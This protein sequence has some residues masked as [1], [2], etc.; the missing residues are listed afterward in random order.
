MEVKDTIT[1]RGEEVEVTNCMMKQAD[2]RFFPENPRIYSIVYVS[3]E[4]PRQDKIEKKLGQLDHVKQLV[5]SIE[6]NKGLIDPLIVRKGDNT[7]LEGN[8]RLAAYRLLAKKD[9]IMWGKVKCSMLPEDI[10]EDLIFALLGEYHIIGRKDWAPFEQAGYLYRRFK[11]HGVTPARM[12]K[13]LALSVMKINHLIK[14]YEFM[15]EN[16]EEDVQRWSYYDE[17]L[18][19]KKIAKARDDHLEMDQVIV[20]K[21][22]TGEIPKAVD[23][24]SK[25]VKIASVGG[26]TLRKFLET[27]N[28]LEICHER[29]IARGVDNYLLKRLNKFRTYILDP[30]TKKDLAYMPENQLKKCEFE[31]KKILK[32]V[33]KLLERM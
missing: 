20:E 22:K 17:Y 26:K 3:D 16:D 25:V 2:L 7:V 14:V 24:R 5:Q 32:G 15:V 30:D 18:K 10:S 11:K 28:S 13:E 6:A 19:S 29:A 8:S 12:S 1:L 23:V 31:L 27:P 4:T 9:P 33:N 21:I